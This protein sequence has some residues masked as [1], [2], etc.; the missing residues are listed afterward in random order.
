MKSR[1][2]II[3]VIEPRSSKIEATQS[4]GELENLV[5][6]YGGMVIIKKVQ[7]KQVP[8]YKTFIGSGKLE[9]IKS[10]AELE[11]VDLII[12][13]NN[14]KPQQLF[15]LERIFE[16]KNI[17]VW[18]RVDLIL[19]IFEKHAETLEARL[20]IEL[21]ALRHMGP[22]IFKMG[23]ELSRQGGGIGTRGIGETNTEIMKR[24]LA[25]QEKRIR[26]KLQKIQTQH[27]TQ[28]NSRKRKNLKT[29]AIVGY[30]NAGKSQILKTLTQ[31]LVKVKDEL[32]ATLDTRIGQLYLP[33]TQSICLLSDTIGF[34]QNLPPDLIDSFRSTLDEAIHADIILH[35]IDY[36]DPMK[37]KKIKTVLEILKDLKIEKT[38][39]IFV[40]NKIDLIKNIKTK[41]FIKKYKK[42]DPVF[43]SALNKDNILSLV[44]K[45]ESKF[46]NSIEK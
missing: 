11:K 34:I 18:D 10:E 36:A 21:A 2:I 5:N 43:I 6:T 19:K 14:L 29:V 24:H 9:E 45:I 27:E 20:Q 17:K 42:Y 3:D 41:S 1:V 31:K 46:E 39:S 12:F 4:M 44:H 40:C 33:T 35:A 32:F 16:K 22:R 15:N 25:S 8:D 37:E 28:R 13:N 23:L 30:T 26:D 38:T 7:K